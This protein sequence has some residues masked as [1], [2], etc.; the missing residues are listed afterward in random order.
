MGYTINVKD[1][2]R[3]V[4]CT[5]SLTAPDLL[6]LAEQVSALRTR[7]PQAMDILADLSRVSE[8][9][10]DI[11]TMENFAA[12]LLG[13]IPPKD[14]KIALVARTEI[15]CSY[16]ESFKILSDHPQLEVRVFQDEKDA[17]EWLSEDGSQKERI[18]RCGND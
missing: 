1:N 16:A 12:G 10:I 14:I 18:L 6:E 17:M 3:T 4:V 8:I 5:G 7:N 9:E 15:Q 2:V 11:S 13:I